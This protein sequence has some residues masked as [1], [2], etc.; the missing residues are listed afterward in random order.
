MQG[1]WYWHAM[2][3]KIVDVESVARYAACGTALDV[4]VGL[5]NLQEGLEDLC[6]ARKLP[7]TQPEHD[8]VT[9][10]A[11]LAVLLVSRS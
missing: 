10:H 1:D 11:R 9:T 3:Y 2:L 4:K 7:V 8:C 6:H 5:A